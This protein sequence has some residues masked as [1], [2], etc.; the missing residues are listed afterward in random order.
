MQLL[1]PARGVTAGH[2]LI[3]NQ[4]GADFARGVAQPR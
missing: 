4:H 3:E 1:Q 2:H